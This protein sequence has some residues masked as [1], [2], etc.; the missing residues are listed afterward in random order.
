MKKRVPLSGTLFFCGDRREAS[1][2]DADPPSEVGEVVD[3]VGQQAAAVGGVAVVEG[4]VEAE[5]VGRVGKIE[6]PISG[7]R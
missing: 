2:R 7:E 4:D 5:A 6:T 1:E 3:L